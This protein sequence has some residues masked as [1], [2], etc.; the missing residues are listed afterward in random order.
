MF[1]SNR[2]S[3]TSE[4]TNMQKDKHSLIFAKNKALSCIFSSFKQASDKQ[5]NKRKNIFDMHMCKKQKRNKKDSENGKLE[6]DWV[7]VIRPIFFCLLLRH[8]NDG[9]GRYRKRHTGA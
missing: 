1:F 6:G 4:K 5:I 9:D 3:R 8:A 7:R 2:E